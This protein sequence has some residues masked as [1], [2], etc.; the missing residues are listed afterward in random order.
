MPISAL[1]GRVATQNSKLKIQNL[2][3]CYTPPVTEDEQE[4]G[5]YRAVEDL[6][7]TFRGLPHT[8]STKDFSLLREWW[9]EGIPLAAVQ[10]GMSEVIARRRED[11]ET[12]PVVSLSYY[13]HAVKRHAKKL[14]EMA[15]GATDPDTRALPDPGTSLP[16]LAQE[17][18]TAA[19]NNRP[20][21]PRVAESLDQIAGMVET[22]GEL[23]P[24]QVEE[25]LF[26]LESTLLS[27]CLEALDDDERDR[28]EAEATAEAEKIA[29]NPEALER[30][31]LALR[32]RALRELLGLPRLEL[33]P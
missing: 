8:L 17:L 4:L 19:E 29:A 1:G 26:A 16:H 18:T 14:A 32:D 12:E 31:F 6:F 11:G 13:R 25:H 9:K 2:N 30:T 5:Y 21:R 20:K 22:A 3:D 10:A 33:E 7:A 27:T 23:P 15:V 24:D 28:L